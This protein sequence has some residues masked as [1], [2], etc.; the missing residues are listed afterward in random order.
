MKMRKRRK[1][2]EERERRRDAEKAIG[3]KKGM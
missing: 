3:R 1:G 2:N